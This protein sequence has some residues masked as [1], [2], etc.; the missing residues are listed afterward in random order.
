MTSKVNASRMHTRGPTSMNSKLYSVAG[1][2]KT[3]AGGGGAGEGGGK[4]SIQVIFNGKIATPQSLLSRK[5]PK[6][7]DVP[8]VHAAW[9]PTKPG[10]GAAGVAMTLDE[11]SEFSEK[12]SQMSKLKRFVSDEKREREREQRGHGFQI[13]GI[14]TLSASLCIP[15]LVLYPLACPLPPVHLFV[16]PRSLSPLLV[17]STQLESVRTL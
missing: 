6:R 7:D 11:S 1:R 2:A 12:S 15:P 3:N 14:F 8:K 10:E 4:S 9:M 5:P 17:H 13:P 16:T